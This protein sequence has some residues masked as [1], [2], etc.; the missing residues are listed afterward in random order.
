[1]EKD[2]EQPENELIQVSRD[3]IGSQ[4]FA[5]KMLFGS[6]ENTLELV[7]EYKEKLFSLTS[8]FLQSSLS[9]E[10]NASTT[11]SE[12]ELCK[13]I[14]NCSKYVLGGNREFDISIFSL[15][16]EIEIVQTN[17]KKLDIQQW[18]TKLRYGKKIKVTLIN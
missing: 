14:K 4:L 12:E 15:D 18:D 13:E 17:G 2:K 9:T 5:I 11:Y 16:S 7:N 10:L 8:D 6:E 1:M 3:I